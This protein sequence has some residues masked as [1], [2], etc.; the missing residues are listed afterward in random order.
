VNRK[1][2]ARIN[3]D[4]V[5]VLREADDLWQ[6]EYDIAW[7][8]NP[9]GFDLSPALPRTQKLHVDGATHRPVQWYFD[10]LLPEEAMRTVLAKEAEIDAEDAFGL[11]AFYG[12]ESAGSLVL[13]NPTTPVTLV[14][15]LKPLTLADLNRRILNL[16][17]VSLTHDA[18]KRMSLAGAQHKLLVVFRRGEL[19][20]PLPG[21]P[22]VH[23]LKPNHQ[24]TEYPASVMNEFF[25]MRLAQA[26]GLDVPSVYRQYAPEP[27]YIVER[28]DRM[29][30]AGMKLN[31]A[32]PD[33]IRRRHVIDT[34][35]LLNKSRNFK[36]TGANLAAL[37]EAIALCRAPAAA[38]MHLFR[39]VLF[40]V[41]I[42]NGDNHLKNISFLVSEE[43]ISVAPAYDLLSTAVYDTKTIA[44]TVDATARWP[45]TQLSLT[46]G[47]ATRFADIRRHHLLDAGQT[48]GLAKATV[49]REIERMLKSLPAKADI[50]SEAVESGFEK[51]GTH[52]PDIETARQHFAGELRVLRAIRKIVV[53]EMCRQ[54]A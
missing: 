42:G 23:I 49:E 47:T 1:L 6:F 41:L 22:S 20:E 33:V 24:G 10:N 2:E 4:L 46:I 32:D 3:D 54:L 5:G 39:W 45:D 53:A 44:T 8:S 52:S 40:N 36:Y 31:Q 18:P 12:S 21:T 38:R 27:V 30:P 13:N 43:G 26:V 35:Q 11:L 17:R 37:N 48:L 15:G 14:H 7:Q 29:P 50:L 16:P 19:F 51:E 9:K 34:C 28:F 25:V